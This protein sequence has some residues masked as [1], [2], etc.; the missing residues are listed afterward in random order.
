MRVARQN[1]VADERSIRKISKN[2]RNL[3]QASGLALETEVVEQ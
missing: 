3:T 2:S 1:N